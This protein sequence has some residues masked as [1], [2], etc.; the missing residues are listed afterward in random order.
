M[1]F[2]WTIKTSNEVPPL[3]LLDSHL[4][5]ATM[6]MFPKIYTIL[7]FQSMLLWHSIFMITYNPKMQVFWVPLII[8]I[9]L[10]LSVH[11]ISWVCPYLVVFICWQPCTSWKNQ[12]RPFDL[13]YCAHQ[14]HLERPG[15]FLCA[16]GRYV[17]KWCCWTLTDLFSTFQVT[18]LWLM[19]IMPS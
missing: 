9:C 10:P 8:L 6:K 18:C 4:L 2:Y 12:R 1:F 11:L 3:C 7:W 5:P 17:T 19:L 13:F 14:N 16:F 15:W